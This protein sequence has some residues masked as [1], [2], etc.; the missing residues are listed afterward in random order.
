MLQVPVTV[1]ES[2]NTGKR[3]W[4]AA[5]KHRSSDILGVRRRWARA[6]A[7]IRLESHHPPTRRIEPQEGGASSRKDFTLLA[8]NLMRDSQSHVIPQ[9]R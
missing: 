1:K 3:E 5:N 4:S 9:R 2:A 7:D 6:F 8:F